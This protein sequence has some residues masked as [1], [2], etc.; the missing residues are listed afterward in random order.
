VEEDSAED[1]QADI[2]QGIATLRKLLSPGFGQAVPVEILRGTLDHIEDTFLE[3]IGRSRDTIPCDPD[4][5]RPENLV[6]DDDEGTDE[7]EAGE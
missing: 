1:L 4:R 2:L 6:G 7:T 3:L 5:S